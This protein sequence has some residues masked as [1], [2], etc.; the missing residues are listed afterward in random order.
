MKIVMAAM[1]RRLGL[2]E[3]EYRTWVEQDIYQGKLFQS[4]LEKVA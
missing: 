1:V 3:K 4:F 2:T